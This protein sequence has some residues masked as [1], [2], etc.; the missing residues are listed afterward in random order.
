MIFKVFTKTLKKCPQST[1]LTYYWTSNSC[2]HPYTVCNTQLF[3]HLVSSPVG[4]R[5]ILA[6]AYVDV[7]ST[8]FKTRL[9]RQTE[10]NVISFKVFTVVTMKNVVFWDVKSCASCKNRCF[11]GRPK[12]LWVVEDSALSR[13]SI[14]PQIAV[15]FSASRFGLL[16]FPAILFIF[17]SGTRML[18]NG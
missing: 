4:I 6:E 18:E 1:M 16:Y 13:K 3:L 10:V 12:G 2:N 9:K 14:D 5:K 11:G 7:T 15:S 17:V 8:L